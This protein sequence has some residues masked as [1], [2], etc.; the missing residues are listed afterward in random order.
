MLRF[1]CHKLDRPAVKVFPVGV[2]FIDDF[3]RVH[4]YPLQND[5]GRGQILNVFL[6]IVS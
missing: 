3:C 2:E 6:E 5:R 1:I 4:S